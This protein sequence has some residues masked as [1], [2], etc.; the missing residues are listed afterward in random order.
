MTRRKL[1]GFSGWDLIAPLVLRAPD[2]IHEAAKKTE[3]PI[4]E[5]MV[6]SLC[7]V[8]QAMPEDVRPVLD[9]QV[10]VGPY[11][12]DI[13]ISARLGAPRVVVECDGAEFHKDIRRDN[14]RTE[15]IEAQGY[16][17]FRFT[18]S[19]IYNNPLQRAHSLLR[20]IGFADA[21]KIAA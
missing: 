17:V 7:L 4:E 21:L 16:R 6:Y 5:Y 9:T 10:K 3:S 11:R 2:W 12:A 14:K 13:V 19:E 1:D 20:Q 15:Y 18:G 8:I